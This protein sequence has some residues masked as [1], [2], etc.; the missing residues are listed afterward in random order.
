MKSCGKKFSDRSVIEKVLRTLPSRFDV[1]A[2]ALEET[3]DLE[4]VKLQ[5]LQ[6]SLEAYKQRISDRNG[7]KSTEQALQAHSK[8]RNDGDSSKDKK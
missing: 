8:S 2:V 1:I 4:K 6:G 3:R 5:E 7:E